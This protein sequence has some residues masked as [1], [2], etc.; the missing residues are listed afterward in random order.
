MTA[1]VVSPCISVC[2]INPRTSVCRGCYRTR[3]E[4]A[5][6]RTAGA[7]R[8]LEILAVLAQRLGDDQSPSVD[9][10]KAR[11]RR[12]LEAAGLVVNDGAAGET[13]S[14]AGRT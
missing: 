5:G 14:D 7:A 9:D 6:W 11:L 1:Q 8:Q 4:I 12:R 3:D 13:V 2:E 10:R